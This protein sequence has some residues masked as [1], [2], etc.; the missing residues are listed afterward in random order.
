MVLQGNSQQSAESGSPL[1][2][3]F[4]PLLVEHPCGCSLD[5]L[6]SGAVKNRNGRFGVKP[7]ELRP[8]SIPTAQPAKSQDGSASKDNRRQDWPRMDP[9]Q[10]AK[11]R[12]RAGQGMKCQSGGSGAEGEHFPGKSHPEIIFPIK[13]RL[14]SV[15]IMRPNDRGR[16]GFQKVALKNLWNPSGFS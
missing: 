6:L 13:S 4:I 14:Q 10:N 8:L 1:T 11:P 16:G 12:D 5:L 3:H 15:T 9:L 7:G 2:P